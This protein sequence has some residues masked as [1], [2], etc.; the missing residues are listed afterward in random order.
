MT[1]SQVVAKSM[2]CWQELQLVNRLS[3]TD[4]DIARNIEH[5]ITRELPSLMSVMG[6]YSGAVAIVGSGPSLKDTWEQLRSFDGDIIAC[7]ASCQFLLERD[8]TPKFMFCFDADPLMLEFITP[9]PD[10]KYLIGSR[11]PPRTF[12]MLKDCDVVCWHANGDKNIEEILQKAG[13][14]TEPMVNGGVAAVTR[15]IMLAAFLGYKEEHLYGADSSFAGD[16]THIRKSTTDEKRMKVKSAG[17]EFW[18]SPWMASQAEDFRALAPQL[19]DLYGVTIKV[20]GDGLIPHIARTMED[21]KRN[22]WKQTIRNI[23]H[24][25][26]I[27]WQHV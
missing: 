15:A 23:K 14:F 27:L 5:S 20:H 11:C 9:H 26:T 18:C 22:P 19:R 6:K 7:N 1:P 13:K 4:E 24:K 12:D 17:R 3:N 21:E 25:A 8:I 10:I 2:F 16:D